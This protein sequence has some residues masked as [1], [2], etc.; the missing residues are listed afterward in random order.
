MINNGVNMDLLNNEYDDNNILNQSILGRKEF[1]EEQN[2]NYDIEEEESIDDGN[3]LD[4]STVFN[5]YKEK[6]EDNKNN[7]NLYKTKSL[8][9]LNNFIIKNKTVLKFNTKIY[10]DKNDDNTNIKYSNPLNF[11]YLM[12]KIHNNSDNLYENIS[13]NIN[14]YFNQD[15]AEKMA[16][17]LQKCFL[18]KKELLIENKSYYS[19]ITELNKLKNKFKINTNINILPLFQNCISFI[20]DDYHYNRIQ[21][22]KLQSFIDLQTTQLFFM[23]YKNENQ[24]VFIS[25]TLTDRF[26]E[27]YLNNNNDNISMNCMNIYSNLMNL[28]NIDNNILYIPAFEIKCKYSNNCYNKTEKDKKF[29]LYGYEDYYNVKFFTEELTKDRNIKMNKKLKSN[30]INTKMNFEY[31]LIK[32]DKAKKQNF[33][34]DSFLLI[35]IDL[36]LMEQL[37]DFPLMSLYVTKDNFVHV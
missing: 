1:T 3:N 5:L 11:V 31:D 17:V 25:S 34:Q 9:C 36:D 27:K 23:I 6:D 4:L 19:D 2:N 14:N 30:N 32:D 24:V 37:K 26:K 20:Y 18:F 28:N 15:N 8:N 29:N 33:I 12:S 7:I 13:T 10:E 21:I 22:P 16:Q 35:V